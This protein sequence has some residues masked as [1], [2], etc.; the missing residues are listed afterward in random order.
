[1]KE[2]IVIFSILGIYSLISYLVYLGVLKAKIW[3]S[4]LLWF[5][6]LVFTS[7]YFDLIIYSHQS[8]RARGIYFEFGH[9]EIELIA[10]FG[11][12]ILLALL[13]TIVA[14]IKRYK[15]FNK[16]SKLGNEFS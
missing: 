16:R 3:I 15:R 7:Y 11:F 2:V 12:C 14:V 13:F 6:Y 8:L 10:V 1:M 4:F 5:G 9:A